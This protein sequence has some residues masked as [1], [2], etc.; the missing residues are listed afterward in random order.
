MKDLDVLGNELRESITN[1]LVPLQTVG[2]IDA[3]AFVAIDKAMIALATTLRGSE[4]LP[5]SLLNEIYGAFTILRR[6]ASHL[7]GNVEAVQGMAD[8]LEMRFALILK[9]ESHQDRIPGVPRV[10]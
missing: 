3:A 5:R 8:R 1:L 10:I 4:L 7:P 2:R 6:E 9:G